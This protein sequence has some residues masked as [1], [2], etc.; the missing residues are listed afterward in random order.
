MAIK[1]HWGWGIAVFYSIFVLIFIGVLF[2]SFRQDN[3][4]VVD[5]YYQ[6]DITYQEHKDKVARYRALS[7]ELTHTYDAEAH[8]VLLQFPSDVTD[9]AGEVH[10]YRPSSARQDYRVPLQL[11]GEGR[12]Q[13]PVSRLIPGQWQMKVEWVSGGKGYFTESQLI[14]PE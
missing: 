4:L 2:F 11:D 6:Q 3:S 14:I 12:Q 9:P 5:D 8:A 13:I 7:E 1:W 10:F